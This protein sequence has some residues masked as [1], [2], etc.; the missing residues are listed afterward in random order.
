MIWNLVQ[1]EYYLNTYNMCMCK[2][3][4]L[5]K[6][7]KNQST[8]NDWILFNETL[9]LHGRHNSCLETREL[10]LPLNTFLELRDDSLMIINCV[11]LHL[12]KNTYSIY[13]VKFTELYNNFTAFRVIFTGNRFSISRVNHDGYTSKN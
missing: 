13:R 10:P 1:A 3:H 8:K 5:R 7:I 9:R 2:I 12:P 11:K 6:W 4:I